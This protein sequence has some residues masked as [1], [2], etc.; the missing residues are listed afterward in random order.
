MKCMK[1]MS[2]QIPP[3][4]VFANPRAKLKLETNK[5]KK[6]LTRSLSLAKRLH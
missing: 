6:N 4:L 5:T 2:Y 3:N 1:Y